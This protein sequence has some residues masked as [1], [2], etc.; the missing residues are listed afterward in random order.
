MTNTGRRFFSGNTLEQAVMQAA[1]HHQI[2]P[3]HRKAVLEE[4][5][6][7]YLSLLDQYG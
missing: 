4:Y 7:A 2:D 5:G 1:S 3:A 6:R